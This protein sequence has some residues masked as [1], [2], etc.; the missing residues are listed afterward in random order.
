MNCYTVLSYCFLEKSAFYDG[1][2]YKKC[3][4]SL[5]YYISWLYLEK[6]IPEIELAPGT[7]LGCPERNR[8]KRPLLYC[9]RRYLELEK[10][11][12]LWW[13]DFTCMFEAVSVYELVLNLTVHWA[14][15]IGACKHSVHRLDIFKYSKLCSYEYT[16]VLPLYLHPSCLH[17]VYLFISLK[18]Q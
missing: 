15:R 18:N 11:D 1:K 9:C 8:V 12:A 16:Q 13:Q 4:F 5:E 7:L 6:K 2:L 10:N 17:R 14:S 3:D